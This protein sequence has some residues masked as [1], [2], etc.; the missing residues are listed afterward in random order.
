MLA[1][2]VSSRLEDIFSDDDTTLAQKQPHTSK[3]WETEINYIVH[4]VVKDFTG[5]KPEE[6]EEKEEEKDEDEEE[7]E[8]LNCAFASPKMLQIFTEQDGATRSVILV[9]HPDNTVTAYFKSSGISASG[10]QGMWI[11]FEGWGTAERIPKGLSYGNGEGRFLQSSWTTL[12]YGA[13]AHMAKTYW[14][15][16]NYPNMPPGSK[17]DLCSRWL[18]QQEATGELVKLRKTFMTIPKSQKHNWKEVYQ[19]YARLNRTLDKFGAIDKNTP[20]FTTNKYG[21]RLLFG[22]DEV[23]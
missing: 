16:P 12:P 2:V 15:D 1:A 5:E 21:R 8:E 23:S 6:R 13:F 22:I 20:F 4:D 17:H 10:A 18:S 9:R 19:K 11:P 14:N 3:W 7:D